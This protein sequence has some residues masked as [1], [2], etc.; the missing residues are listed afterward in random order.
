MHWEQRVE[1]AA[2]TDIG[3]RRRNNQDSYSIQTAKS[4]EEWVERGHL[5]LVADG[6]GGHAVGELASKIAADT[7]PHTFRKVSDLPETDALRAAITAAHNGIHERGEQNRD[8]NRMGTT[9]TTLIL[10]HGGAIV[11][12]VGDSRCY[13]IRQGR[14][15]QLTFDHSLQWELLRQGKMSPEDIFKR[16]PRNVITRSL[17]PQPTVEVDIEGPYP[18]QPGDTYLLC[19]DGLCGQLLD[20]E[21]GMVAATLSPPDACR[22]L[23]DLANLRGGPDNIT[24]LIARI[25][26]VP[27]DIPAGPVE[28][29]RRDLQPGWGWFVA[30]T[31]L[32]ILFVIGMML[33]AL[34]KLW[35]GILLQMFTVVGVGGLMLAWLRDRDRRMQNMV[36]PDIRPGTPYRTAGAKLTQAF[37]QS[38]SAIEYHLHR[39]AVDEDWTVDWGTYRT[40]AE[41]AQQEYDAGRLDAALKGFDRAIHVLMGG[42]Q[43]Q[44]RQKD[45]ANRWGIRPPGSPGAVPTSTTTP[46]TPPAPL[47]TASGTPL[48]ANRPEEPTGPGAALERDSA[49][50]H[51][52]TVTPLP[53]NR[54][55][56]RSDQADHKQPDPAPAGHPTAATITPASAAP[57]GEASSGPASQP[58]RD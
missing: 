35:E 40:H 9:C 37:V 5:F 7:V 54:P 41:G 18:I 14:I 45:L 20:E 32:A 15:E 13:R 16:E 58:K 10:S 57:P 31:V 21:M 48:P 12:H 29:P 34:E 25:G 26:P 44:R 47:V 56:T 36:R 38:C 3:F 50:L 17:G 39:T 52:Q 2:L 27:A 4:R 24:V 46:A 55:K 42:I 28:Y 23:V 11:G 33:P 6:M 1:Y 22:F 19:S 8:F 43:L 30:F 51:G 49:V 53:A